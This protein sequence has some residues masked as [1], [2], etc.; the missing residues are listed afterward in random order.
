MSPRLSA[1]ITE[2][3]NPA[4]VRSTTFPHKF[5]FEP[6]LRNPK[7]KIFFCFLILALQVTLLPCYSDF[8]N[9]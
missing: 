8:S 3:S 9:K 6:C 1:S 7:V 5:I 4:I 2:T